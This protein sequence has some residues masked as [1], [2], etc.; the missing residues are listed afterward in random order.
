MPSEE[1]SSVQEES[2]G[3]ISETSNKA[4]QTESM[5]ADTAETN[6]SSSS[7]HQVLL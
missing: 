1:F 4:D 5:D 6:S 3:R 7:S 2:A